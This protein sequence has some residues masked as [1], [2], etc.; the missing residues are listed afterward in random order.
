MEQLQ[1]LFQPLWEESM[2]AL[3]DLNTK[4]HSNFG[5]CSGVNSILAF[6]IPQSF[7]SLLRVSRAPYGA[8][9]A[10]SLST[11][12]ESQTRPPQLTRPPQ[13]IRPP[14]P[15]T[16]SSRVQLKFCE[17]IR[18]PSRLVTLRTHSIVVSGA[19]DGFAMVCAAIEISSY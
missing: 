12:I 7:T 13:F 18:L 10:P 14:P 5:Y 17:D 2:L 11:A 16:G 6:V 19:D 9:E 1:V 4:Y 3:T 15:R 8:R